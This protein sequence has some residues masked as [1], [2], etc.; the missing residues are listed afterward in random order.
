MSTATATATVRAGVC[1][2]YQRLLDSCQRALAAWQ[3]HR[4]VMERGSVVASARTRGQGKRLQVQYAQAY[5]ALESHERVCVSCQYVA[6]VGGLDFESLYS[7][8]DR[9]SH[10]G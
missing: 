3:H 9:Q 6:K 8:L 5:A 7:A 10:F 4:T 2:E 1:L